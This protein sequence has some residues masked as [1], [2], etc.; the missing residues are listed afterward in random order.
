MEYTFNLTD[1]KYELD[2]ETGCL[3]CGNMICKL[4]CEERTY[5]EGKCLLK[6]NSKCNMHCRYCSQLKE[7]QNEKAIYLRDFAFLL[8]NIFYSYENIYLYG[9]E[10][11]I[12]SN[13]ENLIFC[14]EKLPANKTLSFFSNGAFSPEILEVLIMYKSKLGKI[15]ITIDG[16]KELHDLRRITK[17][18][19]SSYDIIIRNL[20]ELSTNEIGFAVQVNV[21]MQNINCIDKI[22]EEI[23][24]D[25]SI[26]VNQ[27]IINRVLGSDLDVQEID[28]LRA[29]CAVKKR[30][31]SSRI[32]VNSSILRC[33]SIFLA[34]GGLSYRY[35]D[36]GK[37]VVFDFQHQRIY[38]CPQRAQTVIGNFDTNAYKID[39]D[40]VGKYKEI[41]RRGIEKC[42]KCPYIGICCGLECPMEHKEMQNCKSQVHEILSFVFENANLFFPIVN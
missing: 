7:N 42:I 18:G 19:I 21:D 39:I 27:Y 38:T 26:R 33:L 22:I 35:C 41:A 3:K 4:C 15:V 24:S 29:Y 6:L 34:G 11:L 5:D 31:Q 37:S 40:K 8:E 36:I 16:T 20:R 1:K 14:L 2:L 32:N 17:N 9:G 25:S 12:D 13:M 10:P 30:I 28:V 23:S